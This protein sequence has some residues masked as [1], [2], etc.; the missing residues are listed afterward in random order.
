MSEQNVRIWNL[1]CVPGARQHLA[2]SSVDLGIFDPPFGIEEDTFD[3]HYKRDKDTILDGYVEAPKH[4]PYDVWVAEWLTEVRRVLK[5][6]GSVYL[7]CGHTPLRDVLNA[8]HRT[9]FFLVNHI[10]WKYRFGVY[11]N[12]KY[13]TSHYH[14]LY[15]VKSEKVQPTFNLNSRF[16]EH[17]RNLEG[18]SLQAA[19]LEDVWE[20]NKEYIQARGRKF[21]NRNKL[22]S[23]LVRKMIQ[24]SSNPGDVVCDFFLGNFT[25]ATV[26]K[27]MGRQVCGFEANQVS[28][29]W[30]M[31]ELAKVEFG[32]KLAPSPVAS[33]PAN[34]GKAVD[35]KERNGI[36]KRYKSLV[37]S[38]Y[39]DEVVSSLVEE[40]RQKLRKAKVTSNDAIKIV[41]REFG[42]GKFSVINILEDVVKNEHPNNSE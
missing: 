25:T 2:D 39:P 28:F 31:E 33:P 30:H 3:K 24:Y 14:I 6:S 9:G 27:E 11:T 18:N 38:A 41:G 26:A 36:Y 19:D 8:A 22:P 5:D 20:I 29:D 17:D 21:K 37:G 42:R 32:S 4:I 16:T 23:E 13:T 40:Y 10:I 35:A 12:R 15:L 7:V 34:R 1:Y